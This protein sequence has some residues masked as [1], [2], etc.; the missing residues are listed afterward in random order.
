[1]ASKRKLEDDEAE[2]QEDA[3]R[4]APAG[5]VQGEAEERTTPAEPSAET[6]TAAATTEESAQASYGADASSGA[7]QYDANAA[8]YDYSTT[9]AGAYGQSGYPTS[10]DQT[11][12]E[13][14]AAPATTESAGAEEGSNVFI[15]HL[16]NEIDDNAL[17]AMF[18]PF[19]TI[20]SAKV[21]MNPTTNLSMG[22]G[23]VKYANPQEAQ[24][25]VKQMTGIKISNKYLL[26][27]IAESNT[28]GRSNPPPPRA[29]GGPLLAPPMGQMGMPQMAP[30][31]SAMYGQ[32]YNSYYAPQAMTQPYGYPPMGQ[33]GMGQ[34]A[35]PYQ[36]P[37]QQQQQQQQ[38]NRAMN[39]SSGPPNPNIF[40]FHLPNEVDDEAL[41]QMFSPYG[42]IVSVKVVTDK[43]T[44][45]SRGFG[46]VSFSTLEEAVAAVGGMNGHPCGHKY[47][48]VM[49]KNGTR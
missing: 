14:A 17:Y 48:K 28:A 34:M 7:G 45:V 24:H 8:S 41:R 46:F 6:S 37:P 11:P 47:L 44:G 21:M 1:M 15:K 12:T 26:V 38:Q 23:F 29:P 19:G 10:Y 16:P 49:F 40:V 31:Y 36:Q 42:N 33:M 22:Y 27:K 9:Y 3:K 43:N 2:Q 30:D 32:Y 13:S 39:H 5:E 4:P 35:S 18:T 20:E 25:A